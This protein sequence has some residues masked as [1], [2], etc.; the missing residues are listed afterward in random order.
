MQSIQRH[1][2]LMFMAISA[3]LLVSCNTDRPEDMKKEFALSTRVQSLDYGGTS[4]WGTEA[5]LGVF[6]TK[7]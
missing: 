4:I 7:P 2:T 5:E 6:V 1:K 3:I